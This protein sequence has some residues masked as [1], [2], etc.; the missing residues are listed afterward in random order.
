[1]GEEVREPAVVGG[2]VRG[3]EIT[4]RGSILEDIFFLRKDE[5][6]Q[7]QKDGRQD[8]KRGGGCAG[9]AWLKPGLPGP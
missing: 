4:P 7:A 9:R 1:M 3:K 6:G 2:K 8:A 5:T